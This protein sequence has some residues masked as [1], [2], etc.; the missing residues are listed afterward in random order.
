MAPPKKKKNSQIKATSSGTKKRSK[1]GSTSVSIDF[2][3]SVRMREK[4]NL[5]EELEWVDDIPE[6]PVYRPSMEEFQDPLAY[7]Q[8]IA[9]EAS[10]YGICKIVSPWKASVPAAHVLTKEIKGFKFKSYIQ[11]LRLHEWNRNDKASFDMSQTNHNFRSFE[12]LA[13]KEFAKRFPHSTNLSPVDMEKEY[14]H[15][16]GRG[17]N[18]VEYAVNIDGSAFSSDPN[19]QLGQSKGNLKTLPKLPNSTLRLLSYSIPGVTEPML[20]IGMIFSTFAW[21]VEDHYLYSINYHH[22]GA[23]KS[24]YS[25]PGTSAPEFHKVVMD[26]VY[27][28]E[29]L[30][31][32]GEDGASALLAEKTTMFPPNILRENGV[33]VYKAVQMAGDYV[34]TFPR[35][36]HAG[37]SQGFSIGEAVNFADGGWFPWGTMA[38]EEYARLSKQVILSNEELLCKEAISLFN[39]SNDES[40]DHPPTELACQSSTKMYF[41]KHIENLY[42]N[43]RHLCNLEAAFSYSENDLQ[44]IICPHCTRGCYLTFF[45]CDSCPNY[46]CLF[47]EFNSRNCTRPSCL[48]RM[49]INLRQ[50][51]WEVVAAYEKL[52]KGS[53]EQ[54]V[55]QVDQLPNLSSCIKEGLARSDKV[56]SRGMKP[57]R[58]DFETIVPFPKDCKKPRT[59]GRLQRTDPELRW[60]SSIK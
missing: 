47:H 41:I 4:Y 20:Y 40:S 37:F 15:E 33:P 1:T 25:V 8:T 58:A 5:N 23:P 7:L 38:G 31:G 3:L 11:P 26:C 19:D 2:Y 45:E 50:D 18:K 36:H 54:D 42:N 12:K 24:W 34:I 30:L 14:W 27:A 17:N 32:G 39:S 57:K 9:Q 51:I 46:G 35:A 16:M 53:S 22:S 28:P 44:S 21:H 59:K 49:V 55:Q 52:R 48:G 29:V 60:G 10:K 56:D 43:L 6:C 13:N